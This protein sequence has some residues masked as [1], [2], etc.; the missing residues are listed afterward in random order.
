[1]VAV[2]CPGGGFNSY[3]CKD[4]SGC[5]PWAWVGDGY[6]DCADADDERECDFPDKHPRCVNGETCIERDLPDDYACSCAE[7]YH[8]VSSGCI[9]GIQDSFMNF[10]FFTIIF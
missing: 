7:G 10:I 6:P 3:V 9:P 5:I 4:G 1:M 2:V 8:A